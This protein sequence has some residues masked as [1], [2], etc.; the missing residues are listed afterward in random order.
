MGQF[1]PQALWVFWGIFCPH[2]GLEDRGQLIPTRLY[3]EA[4]PYFPLPSVRILF[5]FSFLQL[6]MVNVSVDFNNNLILAFMRILGLWLVFS[7]FYQVW[8]SSTVLSS[9]A[10]VS[11]WN[12][13]VLE[14]LTL[15]FFTAFTFS[16]YSFHFC[17]WITYSD[18]YSTCLYLCA[19]SAVKSIQ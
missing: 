11:L 1:Y 4:T 3:F 17:L 14:W 6:P 12:K 7:I 2:D 16:L 8:K 18:L 10:S 5:V 19:N 15:L 13:Y 9:F